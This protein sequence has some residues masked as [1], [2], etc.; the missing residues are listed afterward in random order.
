[1]LIYISD[2]GLIGVGVGEWSVRHYDLDGDLIVYRAN[3][4]VYSVNMMV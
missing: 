2:I 4:M 1:M 3:L